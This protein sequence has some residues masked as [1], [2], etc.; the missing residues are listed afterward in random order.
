MICKHGDYQNGYIF[1]PTSTDKD[2]QAIQDKYRQNGTPIKVV[3]CNDKTIKNFIGSFGVG[4][5]TKNNKIADGCF[6]VNR[7]C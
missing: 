7:I 2:M 3:F 6:F 4:G 1:T 5:F